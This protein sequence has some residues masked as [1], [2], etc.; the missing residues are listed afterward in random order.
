MIIIDSIEERLKLQV[1]E[2]VFQVANLQSELSKREREVE[3]LK[4]KLKDKEND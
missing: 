2:L 4:E 3:D 1:G